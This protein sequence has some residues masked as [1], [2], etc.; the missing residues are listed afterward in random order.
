MTWILET[1]GEKVPVR[2]SAER[3]ALGRIVRCPETY[4]EEYH[5]SGSID[6]QCIL[7]FAIS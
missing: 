2:W 3:R 7:F 6:R 5:V 4:G 1:T